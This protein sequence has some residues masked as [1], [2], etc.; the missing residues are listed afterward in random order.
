M[1]LHERAVILIESPVVARSPYVMVQVV[2]IVTEPQS[3]FVCGLVPIVSLKPVVVRVPWHGRVIATRAPFLPG[4]GPK[5]HVQI[6]VL[7]HVIHAISATLSSHFST[8]DRPRDVIRLPDELVLVSVCTWLK[9]C[10]LLLVFSLPSVD[11]VRYKW[12][13]E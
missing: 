4:W 11:E 12:S 2:K 5:V 1:S 10:D 7:I 8:I 3:E 6:V 13:R 9:V